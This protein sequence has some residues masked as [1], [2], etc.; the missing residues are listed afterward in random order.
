MMI[1]RPFVSV[2]RKMSDSGAME[3]VAAGLAGEPAATREKRE[4][5]KK[6]QNV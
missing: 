2:A 1:C 3:L 6:D 5:N 4:A